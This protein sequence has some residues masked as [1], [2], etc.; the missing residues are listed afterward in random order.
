MQDSEYKKLR[1]IIDSCKNNP[2]PEK[3]AEA[4]EKLSVGH[5]FTD[6]KYISEALDDYLFHIEQ[7]QKPEDDEARLI[8]A[9][10]YQNQGTV[11][12]KAGD[13]ESAEKSINKGLKIAENYFIEA[14]CNEKITN[15]N[16]VKQNLQ[17][18]D[19]IYNRFGSFITPSV[20]GELKESYAVAEMFADPGIEDTT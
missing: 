7:C 14:L 5:Y 2:N 20:E 12:Y 11:F 4:V 9:I 15:F 8:V 3:L 18:Y 13:S 6:R 10:L 17:V 16:D 19:T 1:T